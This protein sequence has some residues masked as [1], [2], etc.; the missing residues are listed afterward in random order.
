M[1]CATLKSFS[2]DKE[3]YF[4]FDEQNLPTKI[5]IPCFIAILLYTC[6]SCA[7]HLYDSEQKMPEYEQFVGS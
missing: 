7:K 1:N 2:F 4:H 3:R 5:K 6:F